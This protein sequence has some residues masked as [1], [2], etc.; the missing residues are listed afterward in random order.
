MTITGVGALHFAIWYNR[1]RRVCVR[2]PRTF[3]I[4]S[5]VG[6]QGCLLAHGITHMPCNQAQIGTAMATDIN[7]TRDKTN[8]IRSCQY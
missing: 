7:V 6:R 3:A 2:S 1:P 4:G 5:S 8:I